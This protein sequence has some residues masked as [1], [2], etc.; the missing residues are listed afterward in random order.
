[1]AKQELQSV[2]LD[3]DLLERA[4]MHLY[5][6]RIRTRLGSYSPEAIAE[7]SFV[8]AAAFAREAQAIRD[9][10]EIRNQR[11]EDAPLFVKVHLWDGSKGEHGAPM[12]APDTNEPIWEI[13][14]VDRYAFA[15]NLPDGHPI[16][17][18]WYPNAL[19][20]GRLCDQTGKALAAA[21]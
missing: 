11:A 4:A 19:K 7:Q 20:S 13:M 6:E 2:N 9:G 5:A 17:Q 16:N 8:D 1:V 3:Q 15:P 14:P 21:N 12:L 18:R 10:K